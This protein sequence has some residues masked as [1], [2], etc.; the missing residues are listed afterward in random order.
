LVQ[1]LAVNG[2]ASGENMA[3]TVKEEAIRA[4]MATRKER[5]AQNLLI[6]KDYFEGNYDRWS[7]ALTEIVLN[8]DRKGSLLDIAPYDGIFCSSAIKLGFS[9]SAIDWYSPFDDATWQKLGIDLR[10]CQI[11]ADIIPFP[12]NTCNAAYVGQVL[13]HL[14]YSHLKP[15]KEIRRVHKPGGILVIDVPNIRVVLSWFLL[16][17]HPRTE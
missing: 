15:I 17:F 8:V 9:V 12:D 4:L 5:E 7:L 6:D 2:L 3:N 16:P 14:T 10:F 13:E 11:E 1:K